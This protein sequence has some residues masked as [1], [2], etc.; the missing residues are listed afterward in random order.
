MWIGDVGQD[1]Y[2]E[3]D[4]TPRA[5]SGTNYGWSIMEALHVYHDGPRDGLHAPIVELAHRDDWC[6][7]VGG[8]VY[9]GRAIP[10]L[11]GVYVFGDNCRTPLVGLDATQGSSHRAA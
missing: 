6:A 11:K 5:V 1:A 10:K 3:V 4:Y 2:E 7:V 9:R 8:Y